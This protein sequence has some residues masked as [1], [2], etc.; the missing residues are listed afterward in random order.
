M[1]GFLIGPDILQTSKSKGDG[2]ESSHCY[3]KVAG[4]GWEG[5]DGQLSLVGARCLAGINIDN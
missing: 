5:G 4:K 1:N 2:R 3:L